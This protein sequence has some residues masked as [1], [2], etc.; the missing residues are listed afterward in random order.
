MRPSTIDRLDEDLQAEVER[1]RGRGRTIDEILAHLRTMTD[2]VP[3]RAAMGRHIQQVDQKLEMMRERLRESRMRARGLAAEGVGELSG[4][5]RL[6]VELLQGTLFELQSLAASD[7]DEERRVNMTPKSAALIA[8][9][10]ESSARAVRTD[11][12]WKQSVEDRATEKAKVA[13]AQ[14]VETVARQRGLTA[15]TLDALK[16]GIFG[17]RP[18]PVTIDGSAA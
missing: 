6:N 14:A 1:L 13:A 5:L 12:E 11:E 18:E 7:G 8:K 9:A 2:D 10:L 15:E 3:S 4:M 16:A 17:I